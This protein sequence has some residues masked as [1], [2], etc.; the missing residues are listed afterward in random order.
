[1]TFVEKRCNHSPVLINGMISTQSI[2]QLSHV[3]NLMM[4]SSHLL[5]NQLMME[6]K[7]PWITQLEASITRQ[8]IAQ[9][10]A[11]LKCK[12]ENKFTKYQRNLFEKFRKKF[13]NTRASTLSY[14]LTMLK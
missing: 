1:M 14:K 7:H 13:G 2:V 9:L 11:V 6:I 3:N 8:N 4:T 5:K 10:E 12:H